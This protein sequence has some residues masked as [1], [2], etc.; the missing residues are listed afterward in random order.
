[1]DFQTTFDVEHTK[2]K[3]SHSKYANY[4]ERKTEEAF[5]FRQKKWKLEEKQVSFQQFQ[6]I[7]R[8]RCEERSVL[9]EQLCSHFVHMYLTVL[10]S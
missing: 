8:F 7:Y 1:M 4:R 9:K 3:G 5:N 6:Q 2:Y 10:N